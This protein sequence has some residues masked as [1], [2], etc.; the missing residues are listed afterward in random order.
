MTLSLTVLLRLGKE[1]LLRVAVPSYFSKVYSLSVGM[2]GG[3]LSHIIS[4][5]NSF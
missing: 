1:M 4:E 3:S 2:A 5:E